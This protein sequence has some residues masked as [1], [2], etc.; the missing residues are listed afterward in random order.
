MKK[1]IFSENIEWKEESFE[2]SVFDDKDF[3]KLEGITQVYGFIFNDENK[4]LLI[5]IPEGKWCLP[6]GGPE[7]F[8]KDW[9]ETL[10]REVLEES[11]TEICNI[12]PVCYIS[13]KCISENKKKLK[14]GIM[15]RAVANVKE[16]KEKTKDPSHGK[17]NERIFVS[18]EEFLNYCKW[19]EDG[20]I[21][22]ELALA[23]LKNE[24]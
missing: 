20:K 16:I 6:G 12:K 1:P 11:D 4:I 22:L 10:R 13:W 23:K 17:M 5:K 8:D 9:K 3:S 18:P 15:L 14:Q 24:N 7:E 21:Q 2:V 19:G